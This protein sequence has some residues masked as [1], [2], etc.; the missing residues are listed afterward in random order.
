MRDD[1]GPMVT[2]EELVAHIAD[3][4]MD[5][6]SEEGLIEPAASTLIDF[7]DYG[8]SMPILNRPYS[9]SLPRADG[10]SRACS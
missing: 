5:R 6:A 1:S 7:M 10:G 2:D 4:L 9:Q 8:D 3:K